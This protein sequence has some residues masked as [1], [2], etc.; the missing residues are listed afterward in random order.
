MFKRVLMVGLCG[1]GLVTVLGSEAEAHLAGYVKIG[2][3]W[4]HVLSLLC[5]LD[6]KG[7]PNPETNLSEVQC[8]ATVTQ[9]V[10][11]CLN[12]SGNNVIPGEAGTQTVL[13]GQDQINQDDIT[14]KKKGIAHKEIHISTDELLDPEFCVNSNWIPIA[15]I[16][17]ELT[18]KIEIF[19]CQGPDSD[20]CSVKVLTY[21]ELQDCVLP[22]EFGADNPPPEGTPYECVLTLQD[23]VK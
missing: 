2:G 13:V 19:E 8:T 3:T 15:A 6:I 14:D 9:A 4:K 7:V 16:V 22:P 12:P 11:L 10:V 1:V 21:T 18:G 5:A 20:P 17:I 23:H